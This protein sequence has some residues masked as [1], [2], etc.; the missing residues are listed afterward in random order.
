M[1]SRHYYFY[2]WGFSDC[3]WCYCSNIF[4]VTSLLFLLMGFQWL[5]VRPHKA[6]MKTDR[7]GNTSFIKLGIVREISET[8]VFP[9]VSYVTLWDFIYRYVYFYT[10]IRHSISSCAGVNQLYFDANGVTVAARTIDWLYFVHSSTEQSG[11]P[12][13]KLPSLYEV[14]QKCYPFPSRPCVIK[15]TCAF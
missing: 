11:D 9:L 12:E 2:L 3:L 4:G 5:S 1:A 14:F 8:T 15:D 7:V 10:W 6:T 13:N